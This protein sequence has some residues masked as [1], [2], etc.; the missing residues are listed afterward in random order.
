MEAPLI[1]K[2]LVVP[3]ETIICGPDVPAAERLCRRAS[4]ENVPRPTR[5]IALSPPLP[6]YE[7]FATMEAPFTSK[8]RMVPVVTAICGPTVAAAEKT[9]KRLL[10]VMVPR[11]VLLVALKIP[12]TLRAPDLVCPV[13]VVSRKP[14]APG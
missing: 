6:K 2:I 7:T 14:D 12:P 11:P 8:S 3:V 9:C 10:G 13:P 1:S 5:P 4:G